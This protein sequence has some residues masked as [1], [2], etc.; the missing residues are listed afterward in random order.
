MLKKGFSLWGGLVWAEKNSLFR[1]L[2]TLSFVK[3]LSNC[4]RKP[5]FCTNLKPSICTSLSFLSSNTKCFY[6]PKAF[7]L[8]KPFRIAIPS[9]SFLPSASHSHP[10]ITLLSAKNTAILFISALNP[11]AVTPERRTDSKPF[12]R[13]F[14]GK[15]GFDMSCRKFLQSYFRQ[16]FESSPESRGSQT[17]G[18]LLVLFVHAKSTKNVSFAGSFEVLQTSNQPTAVTFSHRNN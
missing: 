6:K 11:Y 5:P 18:V 9:N 15:T 16:S 8:H 17:S 3:N 13:C 12:R 2:K 14:V 4:T 7:Y 10:A 1:K